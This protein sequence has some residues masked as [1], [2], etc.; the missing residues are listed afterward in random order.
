VL[1]VEQPVVTRAKAPLLRQPTL[2]AGI[3][4]VNADI[5]DFWH[6]HAPLANGC[7]T[8]LI[9]VRISD[10]V[11]SNLNAERAGELQRL[12]VLADRDPLAELE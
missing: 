3:G 6:L 7:E 11:D 9:P 8:L 12:K 5:D 1:D 4:R 2:R 10:D